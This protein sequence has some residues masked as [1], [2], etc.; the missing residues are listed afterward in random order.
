MKNQRIEVY[1]GLA[2]FFLYPSHFCEN[3]R[4]SNMSSLQRRI[5]SHGP[6]Q[7]DPWKIM[8]HY[9]GFESS[10]GW[11][12]PQQTNAAAGNGWEIPELTAGGKIMANWTINGGFLEDDNYKDNNY[13]WCIFGG[14]SSADNDDNGYTEAPKNWIELGRLDKFVSK[15]LSSSQ[16]STSLNPPRAWLF[17]CLRGVPSCD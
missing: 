7:K 14:Y 13:K 9:M 4:F 15:L 5:R 17:R 16:Q 12:Q 10:F 11:S 6:W 2:Y 3:F 1:H 8:S